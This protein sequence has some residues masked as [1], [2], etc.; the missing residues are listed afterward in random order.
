MARHYQQGTFTPKNIA[1]YAGN[2]SNIFYRSSWELKFMNW[3]DSNPLVLAW[4]SEEVVIPYYSPVDNKMHRYYVDFAIK[5]QSRDGTIKQYLVEIK[6]KIQT[7][8]PVRGK[9]KTNKYIDALATYSVN[10]SKWKY[11]SEWATKNNMTFQV[12]TEEH[13]FNG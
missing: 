10:Q 5:V 9:R 2:A 3:A 11:A 12:L 8:P 4:I 7:V 13:L 6:P 1:K